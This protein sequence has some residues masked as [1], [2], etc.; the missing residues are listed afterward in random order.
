MDVSPRRR[1]F[2][3]QPQN[4]IYRIFFYTLLILAGL[5][6]VYGVDRG[7][8]KPMGLPTLT[9]TRSAVSYAREAETHF[10]AG[11]IPRAVEAYQR[12]TEIEPG[13]AEH[14]ARLARIQTYASA[15]TTTD[16]ERMAALE[17]ALQAVNRAKELDPEN[18]TVAAIRAFVLDWKASATFDAEQRANLLFEAEKEAARALQ[19]DPTNTLALV[20]YAE[21]LID[22]QKW[23]Q[24]EQYLTQSRESAADLW[25]W[26]RVYAYYLETQGAYSRAIEAYDRAIALAPNMTFLYI[27]AGANYRQTGLCQPAQIQ[28]AGTTV[29]ACRSNTLPAP[30]PSTSNWGCGCPSLTFRLPAPTQTGDYFA[31]A[32]NIQKAL[33]YKPA[34]PD[35]YGQL[36]HR[37]PQIAQL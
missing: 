31:A 20:F 22:Q 1:L 37:L 6:I 26:H 24:G 3:H 7:T 25:D 14:W 15:L 33:D 16:A 11:A 2:H 5:W 32:I 29:R 34:D 23:S 10:A 21:V 13:N 28:T 9:P 27:Y 35:I 8:V 18:S 12:A 4:N 17:S 30:P 19:L 36:R